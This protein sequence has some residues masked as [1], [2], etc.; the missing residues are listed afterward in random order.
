MVNNQLESQQLGHHITAAQAMHLEEV[1]GDV[2]MLLDL[3]GMEDNPLYT[4]LRHDGSLKAM[5]IF[6]LRRML[7]T[8]VSRV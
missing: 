7:R 3:A 8:I 4:I 6:S 2:Q 1:F 5:Q